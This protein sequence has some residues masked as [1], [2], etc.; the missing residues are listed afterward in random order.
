[1]YSSSRSGFYY[2]GSLNYAAIVIPPDTLTRHWGTEDYW[3]NHQPRAIECPSCF[4]SV[5]EVD[6]KARRCS[7][8][9]TRFAR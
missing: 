4:A 2:G 6:E 7:F 9:G 8:C 5:D 3:E 1:M